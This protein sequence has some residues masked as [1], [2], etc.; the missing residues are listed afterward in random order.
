MEVPWEH[1]EGVGVLQDGLGALELTGSDQNGLAWGRA[2]ERCVLGLSHDANGATLRCHA[3]R[4]GLCCVTLSG[5]D[6]RISAG[7]QRTC[8][9]RRHVTLAVLNSGSK[10]SDS[11]L[12][13]NQPGLT[14]QGASL[15]T[16]DGRCQMGD[17]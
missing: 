13:F 17:S 7:C 3:A 4:S 1:H 2:I 16:A 6:D 9:C 8:D 10:Q 14:C 12:V 5:H 11:W 15:S